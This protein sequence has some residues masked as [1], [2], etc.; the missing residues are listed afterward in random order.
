MSPRQENTVCSCVLTIWAKYRCT[1]WPSWSSFVAYLGG[2][3]VS[4]GRAQS[5]VA[6][7]IKIGKLPLILYYNRMASK[8]PGGTLFVRWVWAC[9]RG[10]VPF[11]LQCFYFVLTVPNN[12]KW[13]W[14][15]FLK[16]FYSTEIGIV[17][18]CQKS[19]CEFKMD[20]GIHNYDDMLVDER[21]CLMLVLHNNHT[22]V[23]HFLSSYCLYDDNVSINY[24]LCSSLTH[25]GNRIL[26]F[27][28]TG[29]SLQ[30]TKR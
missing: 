13:K 28:S 4:G 29:D 5:D 24:T 8:W 20:N 21:I 30:Y 16:T 18:Q 2:Y 11:E 15:T 9:S 17:L 27:S 14:N 19:N 1:E 7:T 3:I 25:Y 23:T 22:R 6:Q 12:D 26:S 10:P